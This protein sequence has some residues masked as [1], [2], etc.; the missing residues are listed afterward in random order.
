MT[1]EALTWWHRERHSK[2][3][4]RWGW[5]RRP[6]CRPPP[7]FSSPSPSCS[8]SPGRGCP[9]P[10]LGGPPGSPPRPVGSC[11]WTREGS[12]RQDQ[13]CSARASVGDL[14]A[15]WGA[16][17]PAP[18]PWRGRV[19]LAGLRVAHWKEPVLERHCLRELSQ[20]RG[21]LTSTL[22]RALAAFVGLADV[23]RRMGKGPLWAEGSAILGVHYYLLL[24]LGRSQLSRCRRTADMNQVDLGEADRGR[25][26]FPLDQSCCWTGCNLCCCS[27]CWCWCR[28]CSW[29]VVVAG[30]RWLSSGA[31]WL[32]RWA[33]SSS[34]P[35]GSAF[36]SVMEMEACHPAGWC[37]RWRQTR[38]SS[39]ARSFPLFRR[40]HQSQA[41]PGCLGPLFHTQPFLERDSLHCSDRTA[42]CPARQCSAWDEI[43][44][45]HRPQRLAAAVLW[46]VPQN[47]CTGCS[48]LCTPGCTAAAAHSD[49]SCSAAESF[50]AD[51]AALPVGSCA[52]PVARDWSLPQ[53]PCWSLG[54]TWCSSQAHPPGLWVFPQPGQ[55][56]L[57]PWSR[58]SCPADSS[59]AAAAGS[60]AADHQL[61]SPTSAPT[62]IAGKRTVCAFPAG[63]CS[64]SAGWL[65]TRTAGSESQS[66]S[67]ESPRFPSPPAC[68]PTSGPTLTLWRGCLAP[69]ARS[70]PTCLLLWN[71]TEELTGGLSR[72]QPLS[73][74]WRSPKITGRAVRRSQATS[75]PG[76]RPAA[77]SPL[78]PLRAVLVVL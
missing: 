5:R 3:E 67:P 38:S 12:T 29:F 37:T 57:V 27:C 39:R 26:S 69:S 61:L 42:E 51:A 59:A 44:A 46:F 41:G 47:H 13:G 54:C 35:W 78:H 25:K 19:V 10:P 9:H 14:A 43:P 22:P 49:C 71:A 63:C 2:G 33:G 50:A 11:W 1:C 58:Q 56:H 60:A 55:H 52:A 7:P 75:R 66:S 73:V 32:A 6:A 65:T 53:P 21:T 24:L 23:P 64:S 18:W 68:R 40:S 36:F 17:P 15:A 31:S 20:T 4:G 48:A 8:S 70:P 45:F 77:T 62:G 76:P 28:W 74:C 16:R 30:R 72:L 34:P